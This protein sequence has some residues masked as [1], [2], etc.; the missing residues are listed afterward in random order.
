MSLRK[1]KPMRLFEQILVEFVFCFNLVMAKT[2]ES[3]TLI[4]KEHSSC[5]RANDIL[6][7]FHIPSISKITKKH[8]RNIS[9]SIFRKIFN[10]HI[11]Y[12]I[13]FSRKHVQGISFRVRVYKRSQR[14]LFGNN[15]YLL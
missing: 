1:Y 3:R 4:I 7:I 14:T 13:Y 12:M 5:Y 8:M 15:D 9:L 2:T 6:F 10:E 11:M